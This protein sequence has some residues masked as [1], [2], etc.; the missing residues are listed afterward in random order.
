MRNI[1]LA[2]ISAVCLL[3]SCTVE[4]GKDIF[5]VPYVGYTL[6]EADF[7][8]VDMKGDK[9]DFLWNIQ[10]GIGVFGTE[11]GL[12]EKFNLKRAFDAK[13][14]GEF[15]GPMVSGKTIMAYYPYS[16]DVTL[17]EGSL[18]YSLSPSQTYDAQS[19]LL[20]H[21]LQYAGYAYAFAEN[22]N[23]LSFGYAS[24]LLAIEVS[25]VDPVT[26]TS[27]ELVS[28]NAHPA[29]MGKVNPDMSVIRGEGGSKKV[30]VDFGEGILSKT[31][32]KSA[33][34]PVVLP[35]GKYDDVK[36]V[37]QTVEKGEFVCE[38]DS[39]VIERVTADDYKAVELVV[40]TGSLGGFDVEGGLE[41]DSE[42]E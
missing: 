21:F 24:G 12:N 9:S 17:Y 8:D 26:V 30:T 1:T 36:L 27:I 23:K 7:E 20:D 25:F 5:D 35:A 6:F 2:I 14:V 41:F 18:P 38:L 32:E 31:A 22:D 16:E 39:F 40:N 3:A 19:S 4:G 13:A 10:N 33:I 29:G 11:T 15:Y 28:E 34:Y 42:S 37:L